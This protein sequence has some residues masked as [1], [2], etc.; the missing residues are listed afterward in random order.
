MIPLIHEFFVLLILL[1]ACGGTKN[2][3]SKFP[4]QTSESYTDNSAEKKTGKYA[5]LDED[6]EDEDDP[7]FERGVTIDKHLHAIANAPSPWT[8]YCATSQHLASLFATES[9]R[10]KEEQIPRLHDYLLLEV[11]VQR[12]AMLCG[13]RPSSAKN[14]AEQFDISRWQTL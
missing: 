5:M 13:E 6:T 10:R 14:P 8:A 9:Q 7:V 4:A 2:V 12:T 1:V 11:E 3:G